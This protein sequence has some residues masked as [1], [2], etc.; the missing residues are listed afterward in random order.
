MKRIA[1]TLIALALASASVSCM[2][3]KTGKAP[4]KPDSE[5]TTSVTES[6]T[7]DATTAPVTTTAARSTTTPPVVTT[8]PDPLGGGAFEYN[9]DG[10]VVFKEDSSNSEERVLIQAAQALFDSACR[11]EWNFI[12][13]CPFKTD[14]SFIET[15]DFN[16]RYYHISDSSI[17]TFADVEKAYYKVFSDRYP[18]KELSEIFVE[19]DGG[20]YAYCGS[21]GTDIYYTGSKVTGIKSRSDDE[22]VFTVENYYDGSDYGEGA[23][24]ETD[25][26]S[27][28]IGSDSVWKAG[29]FQ[30]PY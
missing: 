8:Q 1:I 17:K 26:F 4:S 7:E 10:A 3:E 15:G 30:M 9:S 24:T 5:K 19:S 13:G 2:G 11:T 28:V 20:V 21:K 29:K 6:D 23:H 12:V 27:A 14:D 22:I 16:W 18:N 25:E